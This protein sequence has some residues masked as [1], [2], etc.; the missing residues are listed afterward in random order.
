M[1]KLASLILAGLLSGC[2]TNKELPRLE[3]F[4]DLSREEYI[5]GK[6]DCS[7]KA[8]TYVRDLREHGKKADVLIIQK[9]GDKY[10][11]AVVRIVYD[12]D[13]FYLDP[14][15]RKAGRDLKSIYGEDIEL[16]EIVSDTRLYLDIEFRK[17]K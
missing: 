14:T 15:Q 3:T 16:I 10:S 11:H 7:N 1:K 6:N 12:H 4:W 17:F 2:T 13:Y 5:F 9:P 8:G